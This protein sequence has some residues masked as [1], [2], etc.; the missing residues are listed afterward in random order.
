M[1]AAEIESGEIA[2][3]YGTYLRTLGAEEALVPSLAN[4]QIEMRRFIA[5][6]PEGKWN[7][8]YAAD[9]WTVAEVLLHLV[10]AERVF[11]YRALR[12]GRNDATELPGFDQDMYVGESRGNDREMAGI[13]EEYTSVRDATLSLF[14]QF[15]DAQLKRKGLCSGTQ[16]SVGALGFI[17]TGHQR[18]HVR[19][20]NERYL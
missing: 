5:E 12:F 18:H 6:I 19:I 10:D 11:Q 8:R 17:I 7:H 2:S 1:K 3:F 20:L 16:L 9:K 13:L 4:G 14:K 15:G